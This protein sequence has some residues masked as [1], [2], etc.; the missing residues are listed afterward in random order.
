LTAGKHNVSFFH[1]NSGGPFVAELFF[2]QGAAINVTGTNSSNHYLLPWRLLTLD[3]SCEVCGDRSDEDNN[4][5][6]DCIDPSCIGSDSCGEQHYCSDG[7]DN[8]NNNFVDC[9]D[10]ECFQS[11]S[12]DPR[13]DSDSMVWQITYFAYR[14]DRFTP[15]WADDAANHSV[16]IGSQRVPFI[17]FDGL[18][19]DATFV[20]D[21]LAIAFADHFV[22]RATATI[23]FSTAGQYV[24]GA[25]ID[26]GAELRVD[27]RVCFTDP[28]IDGHGRTD[29]Y[30]QLN[31]A[32][33][34]HRF[35][36]IFWQKDGE[37][38][39][40]LFYAFNANNVSN[41]TTFSQLPFRLLGGGDKAYR[42]VTTTTSTT[43]TKTTTATTATTTSMSNSGTTDVMADSTMTTPTSEPM[44]DDVTSATSSMN[45]TF[46]PLLVVVIALGVLLLIAVI[47]IVTLIATR[48]RRQRDQQQEL[49]PQMSYFPSPG[50]LV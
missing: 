15:S 8:D 30:C 14:E 31:L 10:P 24:F 42:R 39:F 3:Q 1:F 48:N 36:F 7:K 2:A 35:E 17:N 27:G 18:P 16:P 6:A 43:V 47:V 4:G 9:E 20:G 44:T 23:E 28:D 19:K 32:R 21:R 41:V 22:A 33:G 25:F 29:Y 13:F 38:L 12:C 37:F 50:F 34:S 49:Q 5:L 26:D 40:Q 11:S 46:D 45:D